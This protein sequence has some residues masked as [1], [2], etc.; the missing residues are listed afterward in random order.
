MNEKDILAKIRTNWP[1]LHLIT[2]ESSTS[3]GIPDTN[4]CY[5]GHDVWMELKLLRGNNIYLEK[6]QA[7]FHV[8]RNMKGG[9]S[10]I[11]AADRTRIKVL[12]LHNPVSLQKA[13]EMAK[14]RVFDT[15]DSSLISLVVQW[16]R[17]FK[18]KLM[19]EEFMERIKCL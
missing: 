17:P 3:N 1:G 2:I 5:Q 4:F 14:F 6:F 11:F 8:T 7:Q 15:T 19:F 18:W 13:K 9:K 10:I 12:R 16:D